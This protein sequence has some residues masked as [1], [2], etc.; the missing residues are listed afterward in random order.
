M[1]QTMIEGSRG[2]NLEAG[3]PNRAY[4]GIAPCLELAP[5]TTHRPSHS[6][7]SW[8][9]CLTDLF[10]GQSD[11]GIFSIEVPSFWMT[12][13]SVKLTKNKQT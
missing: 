8:R 4:E 12:L 11:G 10:I 6:C 7:Y 3:T 13:V 9:K 2:R 1:S 5:H